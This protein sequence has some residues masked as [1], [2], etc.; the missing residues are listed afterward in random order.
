M[1]DEGGALSVAHLA[2]YQDA[3]RKLG[4]YKSVITYLSGKER[5]ESRL[6]SDMGKGTLRNLR[7]SLKPASSVQGTVGHIAQVRVEG[8]R[9]RMELKRVLGLNTFDKVPREAEPHQTWAFCC[10]R[11]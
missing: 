2:C 10:Q 9:K 3:V 8:L 7:A 1:V 5:S 4:F 11:C 6:D